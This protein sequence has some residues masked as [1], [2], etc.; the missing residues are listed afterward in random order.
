LAGALVF[1]RGEGEYPWT[2]R[3]FDNIQSVALFALDAEQNIY[4]IVAPT[5]S[6]QQ[7]SLICFDANGEPIG[8][9]SQ[10]PIAE[11]WLAFLQVAAVQ[12]LVVDPTAPHTVFVADNFGAVYAATC[13]G[14][15][16]RIGQQPVAQSVP[17]TLA[18]RGEPAMG[19]TLLWASASGVKEREIE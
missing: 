13:E 18:V 8:I 11:F 5:A 14:N 16:E 10:L 19:Y 17:G 12:S 4:T 15:W 7:P 9:K 1:F 6:G 2:W 3:Q